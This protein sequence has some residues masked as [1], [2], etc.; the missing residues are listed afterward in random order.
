MKSKYLLKLMAA[1]SA[2]ALI[3]GAGTS[4]AVQKHDVVGE[5][6]PEDN[7]SCGSWTYGFS[8]A[9]AA[10]FTLY[11]HSARTN[12]L[13]F[14]G[15]DLTVAGG[16]L[17]VR[18][19]LP[20]TQ[21]GTYGTTVLPGHQVA[22][23]PGV[24]NGFSV[25]RWTAPTSEVYA[26]TALFTGV[27]TGPASTAD[28]HVLVNNTS[29]FSRTVLGFGSMQ[30]TGLVIALAAGSVVDFV[31]GN[32]GD[33]ASNDTVALN[34]AIA[35]ADIT[36]PVVTASGTPATL[37]PPNNKL[38]NVTVSGRI[39]DN[40]GPVDS[41]DAWY[42][43]VDE[44]GLVQPKGLIL[45]GTNGNYSFTVALMASRY[46]S[47]RDGRHYEIWVNAKDAA[48]NGGSAKTVITVPHDLGQK[49]KR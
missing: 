24:T 25:I 37:W 31:V 14:W 44:Y 33:G 26:I 6:D 35:L 46:G 11:T 36:P 5:F 39:T 22:L 48:G 45:V 4:R 7:P 10:P 17:V 40:R 34:A 13:D 15:A 20:C 2:V 38:V 30:S 19:D 47:D 27:D 42:D 21:A 8:T 16:P 23:Q 49:A 29:R 9:L 32:G 28:V 12:A 43:I 1:T 18:N 41:C 3:A